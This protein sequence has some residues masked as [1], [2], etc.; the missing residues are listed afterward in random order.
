MMTKDLRLRVEPTDEI[1]KLETGCSS[2][3]YSLNPSKKQYKPPL[4]P[5]NS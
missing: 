3:G 2:L 5:L 1:G 4:P